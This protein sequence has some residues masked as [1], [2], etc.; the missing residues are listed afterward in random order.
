[1][2]LISQTHSAGARAPHGVAAIA[3]RPR[4]LS[5]RRFCSGLILALCSAVASVSAAPAWQTSP[6]ASVLVSGGSMMNGDQFA[7]STLPAMRE[8][9]AGRKHVVLVLHASHPADR[10][11][12]E[13]RLQ[14]AFTHLGVPKTESLHRYPAA[15]QNELL[16]KA[17]AFFVGGGET[18]VLLR[19]LTQTGQLAIIRERVLAGVVYGGASAGANVA[20][21]I[22]GT[23]NDF[24]VAD[25]PSRDAL[26]LLPATI[27]PHHP[28]PEPKPEWDARAGKIRIYLQFNPTETVLGLANASMVRLHRGEAQLVTGR[29]WIYR[30]GAGPRELKLGE[31]VPELERAQPVAR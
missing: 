2:F 3:C 11:R 23:T 4:E 26:A 31:R 29:A 18:F 28:P 16:R 10:D 12:M 21:L 8:H 22:I 5:R 20:G 9:Y 25:I 15:A 14:K 27:N 13:A 7:D 1:M 6:Q 19:E 24:P 17:D 30:A